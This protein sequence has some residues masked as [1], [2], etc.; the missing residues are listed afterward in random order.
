MDARR[1]CEASEH[2]LICEAFGV[3]ETCFYDDGVE[4]PFAVLEPV[5][6]EDRP[7]PP[8]PPS[9]PIT[10]LAPKKKRVSKKPSL[11]LVHDS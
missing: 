3:P 11:K 7:L 10:V 4:D 9:A 1:A 5:P 8:P 6:Q 2:R